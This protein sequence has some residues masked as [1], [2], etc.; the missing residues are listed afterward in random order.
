MK[1]YKFLNLVKGKIKS[2]SGNCVWEIGKWS[3]LKNYKE[4]KNAGR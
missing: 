1:R 3:K 2:N 4:D